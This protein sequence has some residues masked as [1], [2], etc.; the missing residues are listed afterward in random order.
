VRVLRRTICQICKCDCGMLVEIEDGKV[1]GV[2]GDPENPNNMGKLCIKGRNSIQLLYHPERLRKPLLNTGER[3]DPKWREISWDEALEILA[4]KL[5]ELKRDGIE[6][7]LVFLHGPTGRIVDRSIVKRFANVFGT[8]NVTGSWSYC[9]GP[10]VL[11]S[12]MLFGFPYPIGDFARAKL[13]ILWGT[14]PLVSRVHRYHGVV[15]DI[16]SAR[17]KGAKV[18]VIDPRRSETAKIANYHLKIRPGR[19]VY[20]A[21]GLINYIIEHDLYDAEFVE[22][23]VSGFEEL[24]ESVKGFSIEYVANKTD[25]PAELIEEIGDLLGKIKPAVIDRREGVLHNVNGFQTARAIAVLATI[26][27]NVDVEGGLIRNPSISIN[28]ITKVSAAKTGKIDKPF[29]KDRFPLAQD[30]SAYLSDVILSGAYPI[31]VLVV[32]KSN[33]L[34]T[35]PE[36]KKL[37]KAIKRLDLVVVH[38]LFLTATCKYADLVLPAATFFEKAEIDAVPLKKYRWVRVRRRVIDPVGEAKS[39]AEFIIALARKMGYGGYFPYSSEEEIVEE[40]LRGTEIEDY[41]LEELEKGVMLE[42]RIGEMREKGFPTPSGK[43]E[44]YPEVLKRI[45][46]IQ[47]HSHA[48]S[49]AYELAPLNPPEEVPGSTEYPYFLITGARSKAYYHSQFRNV[50]VLRKLDPEPFAEI[51]EGIAEREGISDGD[52]VRIETMFGELTVEC[53][54]REMHPLTISVPHGWEECNANLLTGNIFEPLSG[55]PWYRGIPCKVERVRKS[56]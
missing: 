47:D 26:T 28:D 9:V 21:L 38:D 7:A 55:A 37:I 16:L 44:L 24:V 31:K 45:D 14:N 11:A 54:V 25:V 18:V 50:E 8:P 23:H 51:G 13:L 19:D 5:A 6:K 29:W 43:I 53:V 30:C 34:L 56:V 27:G 1:V 36:T 22:K 10:K 49:H 40:L 12:Q 46:A 4:D 42:N 33:P 48:Y 15:R 3:G 20:L 41:P 2:R 39:E 17:N 32:F 52:V 35:L